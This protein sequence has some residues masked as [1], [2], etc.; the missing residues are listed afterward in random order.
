MMLWAAKAIL[1][2]SDP[3]SL[4]NRVGLLWLPQRP[5]SLQVYLRTFI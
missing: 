3:A 2:L 1:A 4:V 5:L